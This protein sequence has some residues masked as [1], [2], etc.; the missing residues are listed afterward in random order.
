MLEGAQTAGQEFS[1]AEVLTTLLN[2]P[3]GSMDRL[4]AAIFSLFNICQEIY[5]K[6]TRP[7][8]RYETPYVHT[9]RSRK[10]YR[11]K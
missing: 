9:W 3:C 7:P 10:G 2:A 5:S 8:M 6:F 1:R 4:D 11:K